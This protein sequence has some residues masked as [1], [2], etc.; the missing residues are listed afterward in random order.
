LSLCNRVKGILWH[1]VFYKIPKSPLNPVIGTGWLIDPDGLLP[2]ALLSVGDR[3]VPATEDETIRLV[4]HI[5]IVKDVNIF[6]VGDE[7]VDVRL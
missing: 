4:R 5:A 2:S 3:S 6:R 1:P 7:T